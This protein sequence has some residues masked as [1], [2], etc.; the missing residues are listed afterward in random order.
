[1][2]IVVLQIPIYARQG[3]EKTSDSHGVLSLDVAKPDNDASGAIKDGIY[4]AYMRALLLTRLINAKC[5]C[6]DNPNPVLQP[7]PDKRIPEARRDQ[8]CCTVTN[9]LTSLRWVTT[10]VRERFIC[11]NV[12]NFILCRSSHETGDSENSEGSIC[13]RRI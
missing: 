4:A 1:M 3:F 13:K 6:P 9:Y 5:I 12:V 11:G 8:V 2:S 10:A 7:Q